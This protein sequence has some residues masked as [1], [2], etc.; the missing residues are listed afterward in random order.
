MMVLPC[1]Y[2]GGRRDE[3]GHLVF[4]GAPS[5]LPFSYCKEHRARIFVKSQPRSA[6]HIDR[7]ATF[8]RGN[9]A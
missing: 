2:H 1:Q 9:H 3:A 4:C 6:G 8:K 7:L 5:V